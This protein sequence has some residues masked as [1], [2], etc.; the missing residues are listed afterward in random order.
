V[1]TPSRAAARQDQM[2]K[3][4]CDPRLRAFDRELSLKQTQSPAGLADDLA[5]MLVKPFPALTLAWPI[6][7][8]GRNKF[9]KKLQAALE[10]MTNKKIVRYQFVGRD[11]E[12][13]SNVA[14]IILE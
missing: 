7:K 13:Q 4:L 8:L 2:L 9:L 6:Q 11:L 10:K 14:R 1:Y 12:K 3:P 5:L